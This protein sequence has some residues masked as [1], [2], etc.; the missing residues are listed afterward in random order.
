MLNVMTID[1][2]R[3][4]RVREQTCI[5]CEMRVFFFLLW[6][7]LLVQSKVFKKCCLRVSK[8]MKFDGFACTRS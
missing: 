7:V 6:A 8:V 3:V 4:L 1:H 2:R 5:A